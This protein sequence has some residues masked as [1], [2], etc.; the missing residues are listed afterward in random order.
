MAAVDPRPPLVRLYERWNG[1]LAWYTPPGVSPL[2]RLEQGAGLVREPRLRRVAALMEAVLAVAA[3]RLHL[4]PPAVAGAVVRPKIRVRLMLG[5]AGL[6]LR[7]SYFGGAPEDPVLRAALAHLGPDVCPLP[8]RVGPPP[9]AAG[10]LAAGE[11]C[12]QAA[13]REAPRRMMLVQVMA[14]RLSLAVPLFSVAR[15]ST[16]DCLEHPVANT[17][18]LAELMHQDASPA[19]EGRPAVLLLR[20]RGEPLALR[21]EALKGHGAFRVLP[22]GPLMQMAPWLLGVVEGDDDAPEL[23]LD[24]LALPGLLAPADTRVA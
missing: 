9:G 2:L 5:G 16:E 1:L 21:V 18:S 14:G 17:R 4:A 22:A 6:L 13:W 23:V 24:P 19:D 7:L 12:L 11:V 10:E 15:A 20:S 3:P 8:A